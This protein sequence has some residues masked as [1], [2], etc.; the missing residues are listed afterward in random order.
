M[1][2]T[3]SSVASLTNQT[4]ALSL[5]PV[6]TALC[7]LVSGVLGTCPFAMAEVPVRGNYSLEVHA[8]LPR[9]MVGPAEDTHG[10]TAHP[11]LSLRRA[12]R[13]AKD[14][15]QFLSLHMGPM[16]FLHECVREAFSTERGHCL[17]HSRTQ[18]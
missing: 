9:T 7:Y 11:A 2:K 5:S 8:W 3:L 17:C 16:H 1:H 15:E 13:P 10:G 4:P 6:T 12:G 18:N 14:L